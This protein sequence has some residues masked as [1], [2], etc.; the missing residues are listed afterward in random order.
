MKFLPTKFSLVLLGLCLGFSFVVAF[1]YPRAEKFYK[2]N[3]ERFGK[4]LYQQDPILGYRPAPNLRF[5]NSNPPSFWILTD[6]QGVRIGED[7]AE[8][9]NVVDILTAGCS[10]TFGQRVMYEDTFPGKIGAS[11]KSRVYNLGVSGFSTVSSMLRTQQFLH[12]RPKVVVYGLIDD[13]FHRNVIP[14]TSFWRTGSCR[15]TVYLQPDRTGNEFLKVP[16]TIHT[17]FFQPEEYGPKHSFGWIDIFWAI[18][19]DWQKVS[20]SDASGQNH[21]V[22]TQLPDGSA[23]RAMLSTLAEWQQ[24]A[25][26]NRFELVVIY[27]PD[28]KNPQPLSQEKLAVMQSLRGLPRFHFLDSTTRFQEYLRHNPD[29]TLCVSSDDCHP[30]IKAHALIAAEIESKVKLLL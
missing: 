21:R 8:N 17:G 20:G 25:E 3:E 23:I 6:A 9:P 18:R 13:H 14:C 26:K 27:I 12:L 29:Q 10:F 7:S 2:E 28:P 19:R 22:G 16:P 4:P 11:L 1:Y 30:G 5:F 15:P 24:M